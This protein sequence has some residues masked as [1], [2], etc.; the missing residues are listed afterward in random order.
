MFKYGDAPPKHAD[1]LGNDT[2]YRITQECALQGHHTDPS[3]LQAEIQVRK[4]NQASNDEARGYCTELLVCTHCEFVVAGNRPRS[5]A[6]EQRLGR[7]WG[8]GC[9]HAENLIFDNLW[10]RLC[11]SAKCSSCEHHLEST[12]D[13]EKL[14]MQAQ[15]LT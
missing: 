1:L 12:L 2:E 8:H 15:L 11:S 10:Y 3:R 14:R 9:L 4:G 13:L 7:A 5:I 6:A